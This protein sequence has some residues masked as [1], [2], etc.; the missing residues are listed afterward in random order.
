MK[1]LVVGDLHGTMPKIYFKDFDYIVQVG[2]VC[3]DKGMR[4]FYKKWFVLAKKVGVDNL[5]TFEDFVNQEFGSREYKRVMKES[6]VEGRKIL[7]F[8]NSLGKPIF[9]IPGNWDQSYGYSKIKDMDKND[10]NYVKTWID[11]YLG[12]RSNKKLVGGLKNVYD[13][14]FGLYSDENVNVL[15][16]GNISGPDD[17]SKRLKRYNLTDPQKEKVKNLSKE[18]PN[19]LNKLFLKRNKKVPLIFVS[20]NIPYGVMDII[21]DK[22][23][24]AHNKHAGSFIARSFCLKKKPLVCLGG[25]IHNY[26]GKRKLGRTLV[27][28]S[29]FGRDAQVLIDIDEKKRKIRKVQFV[30]SLVKK[31][32]K[33]R[34]S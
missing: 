5:P 30:P 20:H 6:L 10:Y 23:S 4:P 3:S 33:K 16:Y 12:R 11:W 32:R 26:Y 28:N 19:R 24:Y 17:F 22:K 13:L 31:Y 18:F 15:G 2:D 25:H 21:K 14:Q 7:K 8:L 34:S 1:I 9:F 29:G 27:I